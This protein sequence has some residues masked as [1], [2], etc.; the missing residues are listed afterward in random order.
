RTVTVTPLDRQVGTAIITITVSDGT[1]NT[2]TSFTLTITHSNRPP[3]ADA[4]ASVTQVISPNN[5]NASVRLD[6]S[7]SSDPDGDAL[8]YAWFADGNPTVLGTGVVGTPRLNLGAHEILLRVN[9]GTD[10]GEDH[11]QVRV[12]TAAEA[13]E[14]LL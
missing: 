3:R 7:R 1:A 6:G 14:M 4:S 2:S 9:D 8:T 10:N 11:I 12:I 5:V 13:T